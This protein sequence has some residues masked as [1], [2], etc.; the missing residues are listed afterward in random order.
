MRWRRAEAQKNTE[1]S[2]QALGP[3]D[4]V[5]ISKMP[6]RKGPIYALLKKLF[7]KN[8]GEVTGSS[9]SEVWSMPQGQTSRASKLLESLGMKVTKLREDWNH[10]LKR[11]QG[12]M[13]R[14][15]AG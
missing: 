3:T 5:I 4:T 10:I 12:P 15:A 2:T 9:N 1:K 7:C 11:H 13:T 14:A 8:N 6:E